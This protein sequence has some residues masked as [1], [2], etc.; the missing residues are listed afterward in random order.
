MS[1]VRTRARLLH[2]VMVNRYDEISYLKRRSGT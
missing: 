1:P 2:F